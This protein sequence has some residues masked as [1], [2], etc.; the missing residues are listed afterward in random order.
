MDENKYKFIININD[1]YKL[2]KT[3]KYN[4][5]V[6][7]RFNKRESRGKN[8]PILEGE[9]KW[10]PTSYHMTPGDAAKII[11]LDCHDKDVNLSL[12]EFKTWFDER[13]S[14]IENKVNEQIDT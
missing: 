4:W 9:F 6:L 5:T 7:K 8:S 12:L 1:D 11:A 3:D 14:D 10:M 13:C 2:A